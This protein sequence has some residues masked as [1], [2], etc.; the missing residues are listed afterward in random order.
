MASKIV[1]L[2]PDEEAFGLIRRSWSVPVLAVT[3]SPSRFSTIRSG[4]G[5][6]TDRALS[7]SLASLEERDWIKREIDLSE[8]SPFPTYQVVNTGECINRAVRLSL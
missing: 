1:E 5:S 6:I 8:R 7:K 3:T 4:L 2:A